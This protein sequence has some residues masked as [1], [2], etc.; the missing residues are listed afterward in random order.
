M[1]PELDVGDVRKTAWWEH[2]LRF[3]FG[4]LVTVGAGL[5]AHHWGPVVGGLFLAFPSILPASLTL[6]KEHD[7]RS[8]AVDDAHGACLGAIALAAFAFVVWA[9]ARAV[10]AAALGIAGAAWLAVAFSGWW[11][12]F[13]RGIRSSR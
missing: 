11:I 2:V 3:F 8:R 6:V 10:G 7:G 4:G 12:V 13:G 1:M 9:L 5:V